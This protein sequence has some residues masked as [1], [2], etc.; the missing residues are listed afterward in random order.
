MDCTVLPAAA[1]NRLLAIAASDSR[2]ALFGPGDN[3]GI[4]VLAPTAVLANM[5]TTRAI[6]DRSSGY[7]L[8]HQP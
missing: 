4:S 3:D 1:I 8:G 2:V 5:G 6:C 7:A